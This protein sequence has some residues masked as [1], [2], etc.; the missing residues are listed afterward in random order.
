MRIEDRL[1]GT[2]AGVVLPRLD[3]PCRRLRVRRGQDPAGPARQRYMDHVGDS[4]QGWRRSRPP[5]QTPCALNDT[6]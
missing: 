6:R 5:G 1:L 4:Q 3:G 2:T